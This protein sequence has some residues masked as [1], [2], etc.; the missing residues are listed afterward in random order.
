VVTYWANGVL[1]YSSSTLPTYPL[2]TDTSLYSE[3]ATVS[4][5]RMGGDLREIVGWTHLNGVEV[6][7]D[8]LVRPG[9]GGWTAGAISNRRIV[10]GSGG[11]EYTVS[12]MTSY[13][14]FGLSH[15]DTDGSY[16]D[17]DYALYAYPP[18]GDV[19]VYENGVS[20]GAFGPYSPGDVLR[21]SVEDGVVSYLKNGSLLYTSL[22]NAT[23]P[24]VLDVSLYTGVVQGAR[25]FGDLAS[26]PVI[27]EDVAWANLVNVTD[28]G[29]T[30][31]RPTGHGWDAGAVS[32]QTLTGEGYVEYTVSN[33]TDNVM[34]GL[35]HGDEDQGYGDIE[36]ALYTRAS[37]GLLYVFEG[38]VYRVVGGT[39]VAGDT[40]RVSV[41]GGV[42]KYR[43]NGALVYSS[44]TPPTFPLNVDTSLYSTGASITGARIG[45][46]E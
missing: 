9:S 35:G 6:V 13:V 38:G 26:P 16:A 30:L 17:I 10:T 2:V 23:Y 18:T 19:R 4:D 8:T 25:L 31:E 29:G 21:V 39:Y 7:D 41:E 20:R 33:T 46:E 28:I 34:F 37:K 3:G 44:T 36:Y 1:L 24:L 45:W 12:D 22:T 42:V 43:K 15:G 11:A 40:L 27:E 32:S 14:M 5:P